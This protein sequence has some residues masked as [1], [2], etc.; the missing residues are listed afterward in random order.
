MRRG[1]RGSVTAELA[2][3]LPALVLL[4]LASLTAVSA[5]ITKLECVDAAR[6]AV[7]AEARGEHGV[8]AGRRVAPDGARVRVGGQGET[9]RAIV[10]TRVRPLGPYLPGIEVSATAVAEREPG[11]VSGGGS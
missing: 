6:E 4:L 1:D 11:V 7:R 2:V 5:V 10:S 8:T 3:G 9:V